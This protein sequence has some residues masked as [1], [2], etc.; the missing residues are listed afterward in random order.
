M[1]DLGSVVWVVDRSR[2]EDDPLGC[3]T[4]DGHASRRKPRSA[5]RNVL[6]V[7]RL[8]EK[9]LPLCS[10]SSHQPIVLTARIIARRFS[11]GVVAGIAQ[12]AF[13][14]KRGVS[15]KMESSSRV[16]ASTRSGVPSAR[17]PLG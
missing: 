3:R 15:A 12:P 2:R 13:T 9:R 5:H 10:D 6:R 4:I 17:T 1:G 11:P 14:M 16:L 8:P 7:L